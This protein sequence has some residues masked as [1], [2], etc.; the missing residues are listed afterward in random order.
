MMFFILGLLA[1]STEIMIEPLESTKSVDQVMSSLGN[2]SEGTIGY[3]SGILDPAAWSSVPSLALGVVYQRD[4]SCPETL[5]VEGC[6]WIPDFDTF[7]NSNLTIVEDEEVEEKSDTTVL[8]EDAIQTGLYAFLNLEMQADSA[9]RLTDTKTYSAYIFDDEA[10]DAEQERF[11]AEYGDTTKE[12]AYVKS[13]VWH[14]LNIAE[15]YF[16]SVTEPESWDDN[17]TLYFYGD[18]YYRDSGLFLEREVAVITLQR[19]RSE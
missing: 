2:S 17:E 1:C 10:L 14:R 5:A 13:I 18:G 19:M 4:A 12:Q 3:E 6:I 16:V 11:L 9:V 15:Y 8:V 7:R